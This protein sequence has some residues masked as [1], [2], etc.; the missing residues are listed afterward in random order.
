MILT[1]IEPKSHKHTD[2]ELTIFDQIPHFAYSCET[3][4]MSLIAPAP[5]CAH[6]QTTLL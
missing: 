6:P 4:K 2:P 5:R 3:K 1:P